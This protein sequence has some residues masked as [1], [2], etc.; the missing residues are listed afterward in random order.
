M[1]GCHSI[2]QFSRCISCHPG[3]YLGHPMGHVFS[4]MR[5]NHFATNTWQ[6]ARQGTTKTSV[7]PL[8]IT[9][10]VVPNNEVPRNYYLSGN[11]TIYIRLQAINFAWLH[12]L[13]DFTLIIDIGLSI[14]TVG[15]E[16]LYAS[17]PIIKP[18]VL[19]RRSSKGGFMPPFFHPEF[20]SHRIVSLHTGF[21]EI[22]SPAPQPSCYSSF[23]EMEH[24]CSGLRFQVRAKPATNRACDGRNLNRIKSLKVN[25][26]FES[27]NRSV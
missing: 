24:S 3:R 27:G 8:A 4:L 12:H 23:L 1:V 9:R 15:S 2:G 10:H 19:Y 5:R 6:S 18:E 13:F 21:G 20:L 25:N 22:P 26:C 11:F 14:A 17:A 7:I 16:C